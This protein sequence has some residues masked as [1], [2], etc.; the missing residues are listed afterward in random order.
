[1]TGTVTPLAVLGFEVAADTPEEF[2]A[3]IRT[4]I[5]KRTKIIRAAGIEGG[6]TK[7]ASRKGAQF[8]PSRSTISGSANSKLA[9]WTAVAAN[10]PRKGGF[11]PSRIGGKNDCHRNDKR[12]RISW[13]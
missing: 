9:V 1:M 10:Q 2:T 7:L 6:L 11:H 3:R 12:D 4:D 8:G 5:T 13:I